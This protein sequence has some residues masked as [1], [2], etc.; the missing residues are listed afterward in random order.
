MICYLFSGE[1]VVLEEAY[2]WDNVHIEEGCTVTMSVLADG[3]HILPRT[4]VQ[5]GC[6]LSTKVQYYYSETCDD[7]PLDPMGPNCVVLKHRCSLI[8]GTNALK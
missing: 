1:N 6:V 8:R 7:R 2:L 4:T 5:R 3:V